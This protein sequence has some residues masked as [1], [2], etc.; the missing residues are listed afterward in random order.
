MARSTHPRLRISHFLRVLLEHFVGPNPYLAMTHRI[1]SRL[2]QR[3][4]RPANSSWDQ[5]SQKTRTLDYTLI[6]TMCRIQSPF[7]AVRRAPRNQVHEPDHT[8]A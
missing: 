1:P 3:S 2:T 5:D 4:F 6:S 8:I 7:V